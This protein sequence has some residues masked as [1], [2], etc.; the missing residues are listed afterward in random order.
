MY[1]SEGSSIDQW[2]QCLIHLNKHQH[3]EMIS[4]KELNTALCTS[5]GTI[6]KFKGECILREFEEYPKSRG[7][8]HTHLSEMALLKG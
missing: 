6:K 2:Y 7:I 4:D 1:C 3:S 8:C 5:F